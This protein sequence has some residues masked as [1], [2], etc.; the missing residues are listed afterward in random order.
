MATATTARPQP[1][2]WGAWVLAAL[3]LIIAALVFA[4]LYYSLANPD[5]HWYGL[6]AIGIVALFFSLGSY[7][8]ESAS[9]EPTIQRSLAWGFFGMGFAVLLFTVGLGTMYG[10][11][12][13]VG[14]LIGL[15]VVVVALFVSVGLMM[16][17]IR[18]VARTRAREPPREAW[19]QEP[20][21]SALSYATATSP[22][23][24]AVT[25]PPSSGN[26][27]QRSP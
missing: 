9:R 24:P 22:S 7:L 27:P 26:P 21:P 6:L 15:I 4:G 18:S 23:V 2:G 20:T 12:D 1:A 11:T 10:V 17:R 8:A 3:F 14:V 13:L 25:P 5:N 16:W 19:R